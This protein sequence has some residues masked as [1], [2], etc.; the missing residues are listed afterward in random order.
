MTS[1]FGYWVKTK[2]LGQIKEIP[3]GRSIGHISCSDDLKIGQ[4]ACLSHLGS[5]TTSVCQIK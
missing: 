2:S 3:C 4:D 1:N 5:K